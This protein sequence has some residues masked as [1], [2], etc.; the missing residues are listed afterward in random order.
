M[1]HSA[2]YVHQNMEE[3]IV[4]S[5][6][7]S[8]IPLLVTM[9][10]LVLRV[11]IKTPIVVNVTENIMEIIVSTLSIHLISVRILPATITQLVAQGRVTIHVPVLMELEDMI[12][13]SF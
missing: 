9:E 13:Q 3:T 8:A 10:V 2:V 6:F 7:L 12:A 11:R 4:R 5:L 1:G